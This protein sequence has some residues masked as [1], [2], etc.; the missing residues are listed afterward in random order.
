MANNEKVG[1]PLFGALLRMPL[2]VILRRMLD[3]LAAKGFD[4]IV[5]AHFA[6][7]RYPGPDG[8]RPSDLAA[9]ANMSKQAMNYLLGQLETLAYIERRDDAEDRRSK[10]VYTTARGEAAREVIRAEIAAVEREWARAL[11]REDLEQLRTL[12]QRLGAAISDSEA[13]SYFAVTGR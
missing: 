12:L 5:P 9:R 11:G 1:P 8:D 6:V 7:L 2:E 3:A 13:E 10:R 4:D